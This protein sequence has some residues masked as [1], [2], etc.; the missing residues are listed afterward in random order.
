MP[1][2]TMDDGCRI[3]VEVEGKDKGPVL[4]LSNSLGTN[5]TMWDGQM[6]AFGKAFRVV[7]YDSRGHGKSDAPAG[8]YSIARLGRDALA[9]MDALK[10][11]KV[12]WCGLSKGGMVGQWVATHAPDRIGKLVLCN[13]A[14]QMPTPAMWNTRISACLSGGMEGL[15][16]TILTRWFTESFR[17]SGSSELERVKAMVLT[18]PKQG[19]AACS[20]AIRDMDQREAIR[21]V[22][23]PTLVVVG[24]KD[25]ATTPEAGKLIKGRIKGAKLVTLNAAHLSNIEQPQAFT[26][27]VIGFLKAKAA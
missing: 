13:T 1:K 16:E 4:M 23:A 17:A 15:V 5:L 9:V 8:P 26:E 2:I 24:R 20:G 12:H 6:K 25:P 27:A 14:A 10:L 22:T 7:R 18:T 3:H 21:T 19:Y 11:D